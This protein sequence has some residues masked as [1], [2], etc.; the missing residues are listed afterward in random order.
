MVQSMSKIFVLILSS[1]NAAMLARTLQS[2]DGCESPNGQIGVIVVENGQSSVCETVCR[3]STENLNVCHRFLPGVDKGHALNIAIEALPDDALLV[4]SDDDIRYGSQTLVAYERAAKR[5]AAPSFFGGPFGCDY[6][7][8]P[9][10]WIVPYLPVSA[11]GWSPHL[12][13]LDPVRDRFQ[14]FNWAAFVQDIKRCGGFASRP[15]SPSVFRSAG[16]TQDIGHRQVG[17]RQI[18]HHRAM[19][20]RM[21]AAGM[22]GVFVPDA[23]VYR[24]VPENRCS[25]DWAIQ[26]AHRIGVSRGV[27]RREQ[28]VPTIALHH[29]SNG[30]GLLASTALKWLSSLLPSSKLHFHAQHRQ[31]RTLGYFR[32]FRED[33]VEQKRGAA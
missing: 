31:Q 12:E 14:P 1:G 33:A 8:E 24:F 21:Q 10:P 6:E 20:G 13:T 3:R 5:I 23:F 26:R 4:L 29:W 18:G 22:L 2:I 32:G 30:I 9:L 28:T 15:L 27:A 16:P 25:V 11:I 19:Q 7:Q 17:H